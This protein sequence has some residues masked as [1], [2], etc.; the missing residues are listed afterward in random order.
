MTVNL[1]GSFVFI[2]QGYG[3]LSSVY[4]N[5]IDMEPFPETA[6]RQRT[7]PQ[8]TDLFEGAYTTIWLETGYVEDR[9]DL[10]IIRQPNGTYKLRWFDATATW[11]D[12][13]GFLHD[14]KLVGAYWREDNGNN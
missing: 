7:S 11:F 3:V 10:K 4:H 2:N 12:G 13:I 1:I 9:T 8:S 14:D 5:N 6:K